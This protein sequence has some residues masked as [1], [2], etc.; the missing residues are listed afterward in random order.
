[1]LHLKLAGKI[2]DALASVHHSLRQAMYFLPSKCFPLLIACAAGAPYSSSARSAALPHPQRDTAAVGKHIVVIGAGFAGLT[3][4]CELAAFGYSVVVIDE[5]P[6]PGGRAQRASSPGGYMHDAGPSWYWMPQVFDDV[7][8]RFGTRVSDHYNLTR[9]D[10]AYRLVFDSGDVLAVPGTLTGMLS[11]A[12]EMD[13]SADM[14]GFF[15]DGAT[16]YDV[17]VRRALW[18]APAS[19]VERWMFSKGVHPALVTTTLRDHIARYTTNT[20]LRTLLEWPSKFIGLDAVSAPS[21]YALL[22]WSGHAQ[23]T[24][25][26]SPHGM[27]APA[28]AL[29]AIALRLGVTFRFRT[30]VT[31]IVGGEDRRSVDG[32]IATDI[33]NNGAREAQMFKAHGVIAAADYAHVELELLPTSLRRHHRSYWD[34]RDMTPNA[35]VFTLCVAAMVPTL[36]THHTLFLDGTGMPFY[37]STDAAQVPRD[38]A[39]SSPNRTSL[40]ILVPLTGEGVNVSEKVDANGGIDDPRKRESILSSILTRLGIARSDIVCGAGG[41]GPA[42][43]KTTFHAWQ[44]NAFGLANTLRQTLWLKPS[45]DSLARNLVYAGHLTHPG[46]GVP[47]ALISGIV[48]AQMLHVRLTAQRSASSL[49]FWVSLTVALL[50]A[51]V[52]SHTTAVGNALALHKHGRTYFAAASALPSSMFSRIAALYA[53]F[54][55][56]D[57]LVDCTHVNA[58]TRAADLKAYEL[59][60]VETSASRL[61]YPASLWQT[62]FAAMRLDAASRGVE[63][64]DEVALIAYMDG[65]AAILGEFML[66]A[67]GGKPELTMSARALG[68]AFQLT[69]ML[70]DIREDA[71][72]GRRYIPADACARHGITDLTQCLASDPRFRAL[73]EEMFNRADKWYKEADIGIAALPPQARA[74]IALARVSYHRLHD[75]IRRAGYNLEPRVVVPWTSKIWDASRLLTPFQVVRI[76]AAEVALQLATIAA[77]NAVVACILCGVYTVV[78]FL[79]VKG[80]ITYKGVHVILTGPLLLILAGAVVTRHHP[81]RHSGRTAY[82]GHASDLVLVSKW[83]FLLAGLAVVYT[84]PWDSHLIRHGVWAST[85]VSGAL[86]AIPIEEFAF[87]AIA[88]AVSVAA[89]L[90]VWPRRWSDV[91]GRSEGGW[92]GTFAIAATG[93]VGAVCSAVGGRCYYLGLLLMW[94]TP[95]LMLQWVVGGSVLSAHRG[96]LLRTI[97]LAGGSLALIDIWAI[98]RNVWVLNPEYT[99]PPWGHGIHPEEVIFFFATAAMCAGGLTLAMWTDHGFEPSLR[100]FGVP[101]RRRQSDATCVGESITG[102]AAMDMSAAQFD[103]HLFRSE[104]IT[105]ADRNSSIRR[106]KGGAAKYMPVES[107]RI[108]LL[109]STMTDDTQRAR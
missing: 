42:E 33:E 75:A 90:L 52:A 79:D 98:Q 25:V 80:E 78:L 109:T 51:A 82:A 44:G 71:A 47:P 69:N 18:H 97:A 13:P 55:Y 92:R 101:L 2:N 1:M 66:S 59:R 16:K 77:D 58:A 108:A 22:T 29:H 35:L 54:R 26:P 106:R 15:A 99:L 60:V 56:A 107:S 105:E 76:I 89:W 34:R 6:G 19:P 17:G 50:V 41:F 5:Q 43:Y 31:S 91:V 93:A 40:F 63:C 57:D 36:T 100:M 84:A 32:V 11:F 21:L 83:G 73:M 8:A 72:L 65:S 49:F 4:A 20:R 96:P 74:P 10:P 81:A 64:A 103:G 12:N 88:T 3:A 38:S 67:M 95:I 86:F 102:D 62:F 68:Y 28:L 7:F 87:F 37:V 85:A 94:L 39:G 45:M 9:L 61:G 23:G 48:A 46:P 14:Q 104:T 27:A 24:W 30:R 70:R 53:R